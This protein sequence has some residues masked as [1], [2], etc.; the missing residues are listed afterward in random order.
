MC[1]HGEDGDHEVID[2][3]RMTQESAILWELAP[4]AADQGQNSQRQH[5]KSHKEIHWQHRVEFYLRDVVAAR[6][7]KR[8]EPLK[9]RPDEAEAGLQ[10]GAIIGFGRGEFVE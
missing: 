7:E 10:R 2:E 1:L 4:Q 5:Q 6:F 8:I 3:S 9:S